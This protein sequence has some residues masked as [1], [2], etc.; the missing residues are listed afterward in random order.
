MVEAQR[1]YQLL[2]RQPSDFRVLVDALW[3]RGIS[4]NSLD[5]NLWMKEI[6]PSAALRKWYKHDAALTSE[7]QSRYLIELSQPEKAGKLDQL[8]SIASTANLILITATRDLQLSHASFLAQLI[9]SRIPKA[10]S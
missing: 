5:I 8:V 3:P 1:V 2:K 10:Q 9:T 6:A 7:F 4:K